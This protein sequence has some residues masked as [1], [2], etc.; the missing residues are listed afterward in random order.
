MCILST[1]PPAACP[2]IN[3][4]PP[5]GSSALR[6]LKQQCEAGKVVGHGGLVVAGVHVVVVILAAVVVSLGGLQFSGE[7][8]KRRVL[9]V[10]GM[11]RKA[12]N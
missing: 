2:P 5:E 4:E 6:I 8:E 7:V 1:A 3:K 9:V 10:L 11:D 12:C